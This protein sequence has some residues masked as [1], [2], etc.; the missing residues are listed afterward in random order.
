MGQIFVAFSEY[1]NFKNIEKKANKIILFC[2]VIGWQTVV[3]SK[4]QYNVNNLRI[5]FE[6]KDNLNQM[7]SKRK[8]IILLF[9]EVLR[10]FLKLLF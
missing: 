2:M 9:F 3:M 1:L 5:S 8:V 4:T 10:R 6:V 7:G